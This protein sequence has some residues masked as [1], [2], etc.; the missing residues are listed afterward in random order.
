MDGQTE[1]DKDI[2][3]KANK[4]ALI[5]EEPMEPMVRHHD[6]EPVNIGLLDELGDFPMHFDEFTPD[7]AG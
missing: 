1:A 2:L 6:E 7:Y 4:K 3:L 5:N